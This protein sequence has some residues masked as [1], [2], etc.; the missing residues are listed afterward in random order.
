MLCLKRLLAVEI[1]TP[2]QYNL[3]RL[4]G[5]TLTVQTRKRDSENGAWSA[6]TRWKQGRR[7]PDLDYYTIQLETES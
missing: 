1:G 5:N 6:D 7:K 4:E 3:V 2:W